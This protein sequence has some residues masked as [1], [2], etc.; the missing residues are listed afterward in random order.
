MYAMLMSTINVGSLIAGQL[1]GV[2]TFILGITENNF[3]NLW[4]LVLIT[5]VCSC[6]PLF[7]IS[8]IDTT[9]SGS[10]EE[11]NGKVTRLPEEETINE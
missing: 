7:A 10:K 2:I 11:N 3:S 8:L 4:L 5:N 6:L 1:G 9:D